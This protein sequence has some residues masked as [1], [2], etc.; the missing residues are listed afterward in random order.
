MRDEIGTTK[1]TAALKRE[2]REVMNS[3]PADLKRLRDVFAKYGVTSEALRSRLL[4]LMPRT[5]R[6]RFY[7]KNLHLPLPARL[8]D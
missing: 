7:V 8:A 2:L 4:N 3:S 1:Q 6:L 5:H